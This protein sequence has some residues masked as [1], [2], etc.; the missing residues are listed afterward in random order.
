MA[1]YELR[2]KPSAVKEL[3]ALL[4]QDRRRIATRIQALAED[5]RPP[6]C[7]KLTGG[8]RYRIRQGAFR[9][10]YEVDDTARN[11]TVVKIGHRRDV[12]R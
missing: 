5:C 4:I 7:Q 8:D 10:L 9:V 1:S 6:G 11:V 2:I 3:Q 12:Y